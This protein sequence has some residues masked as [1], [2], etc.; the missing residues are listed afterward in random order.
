VKVT[1]SF[2]T[3]DERAV[4]LKLLSSRG[5]RFDM[6]LKKASVRKAQYEKINLFL[7]EIDPSLDLSTVKKVTDVPGV[8]LQQGLIDANAAAWLSTEAS[9]LAAFDKVL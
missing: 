4:W 8:L 1:K 5:L 6:E 3:A 7:K 9:T 2:L